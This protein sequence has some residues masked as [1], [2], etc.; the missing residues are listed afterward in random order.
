MEGD[1]ACVLVLG[2]RFRVATSEL[3]LVEGGG[4][5]R[6]EGAIHVPEPEAIPSEVHVIGRTVEEAIEEV[7]RAIDMELRAGGETL[8][9]VHG[10]GTGRLRAGLREHLRRHAAVASLRPGAQREGGNGATVVTLK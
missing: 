7:D 1:S 8:R 9:V 5:K 10:H 6:K 4:P 3:T 2:K